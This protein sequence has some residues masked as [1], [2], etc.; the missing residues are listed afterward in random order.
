MKRKVTIIYYKEKEIEIDNCPNDILDWGHEHTEEAC[1][2]VGINNWNLIA[3][4]DE[5]GEPIL[6]RSY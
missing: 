2:K 6:Q 5:H 1:R 3:I 4:Y